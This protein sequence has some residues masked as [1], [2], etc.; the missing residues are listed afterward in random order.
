MRCSRN[1]LY[2]RSIHANPLQKLHAR[3]IDVLEDWNSTIERE[4]VSQSHPKERSPSFLRLEKSTIIKP[5]GNDRYTFLTLP[6]SGNS[7]PR[8]PFALFQQ[9]RGSPRESLE[10]DKSMTLALSAATSDPS[11]LS[12]ALAVIQC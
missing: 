7:F 2:L 1:I 5:D 9:D 4:Y 10:N 8:L 6:P 12:L 11:A 3:G